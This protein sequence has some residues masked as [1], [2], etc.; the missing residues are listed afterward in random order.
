MSE[1]ESDLQGPQLQC[2][3]CKDLSEFDKR[4]NG[5]PVKE[6]KLCK[7]NMDDLI[8]KLLIENQS[9]LIESQNK[10][11]EGHNKLVKI[12]YTKH[13]TTRKENESGFR[14]SSLQQSLCS[15]TVSY[16]IKG[17]KDI[18]NINANFRL[19]ET[20][21]K[22][23]SNALKRNSNCAKYLIGCSILFFTEWI[24]FQFYDGMNWENRGQHWHL[25]H[26]IPC[27]DF[28]LTDMKQQKMF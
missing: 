25:D 3:K 22:K 20:L 4:K 6:C 1:K 16:N 2:F 11:L 8:T 9:K 18:N 5:K 27:I 14:E 23:V 28:D 21:R 24:E 17:R 12:Q 7:Q 19:K 10:L 13:K 15:R 26:V